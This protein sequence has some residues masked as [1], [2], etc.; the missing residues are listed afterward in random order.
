MV[1]TRCS[2][3]S[4]RRSLTRP[5]EAAP[6][7]IATGNQ[8]KLREFRRLLAPYAR[9]ILSPAEAGFTRPLV[10]SGVSYGENALSKALTVS[11]A[12][13]LDALGDDSGIEVIALEGWPG[14]RSARWLGPEATDADRLRGLL[15]EVGRRTPGDRRVR[16]VAALALARPGAEPVLVHGFCAGVLVEP[17]GPAGFG[18]DPAFLSS[19]LGRTF[20]EAVDAEKDRVS[21]RGR[22]LAALGNQGVL[23]M[24]GPPQCHP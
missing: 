23:G 8:A 12:T 10:E 1:W 2:A 7:L 21:H 11:D 4:A 9:P 5:A 6:L 15:D 24:S 13:G 3:F 16:Y 18:Y 19:D 14:P 17:R 22:A 20:G